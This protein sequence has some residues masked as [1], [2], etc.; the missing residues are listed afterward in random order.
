MTKELRMG[1]V[2]AVRLRGAALRVD[3]EMLYAEAL[4]EMEDGLRRDGLWAKAL[5]ECNMRQSDAQAS[6]LKLRVQSLRDEI[7]IVLDQLRRNDR[8]ER[9]NAKLLV[10]QRIAAEQ[11]AAARERDRPPQG[12]RDWINVMVGLFAV[13]IVG[14]LLATLFQ[15]FR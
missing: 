11:A 8:L 9:E 14:A 15:K 4:R 5:V 2:D 6:Y 1:I 7:E 3:E 10:A 13:V 12:I